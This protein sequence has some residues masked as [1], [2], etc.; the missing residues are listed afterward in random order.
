MNNFTYYIPTKV[1]FGKDEISKLSSLLK[2]NNVTKVMVAFGGGSIK[3]NGI[4]ESIQTELKKE[5]ISLVEF[6]GIEPNPR[7]KSVYDGIKTYKENGCDFILAVGGGSTI[8]AVKAMS[9]GITYDGDVLELLKD[10]SKIT[11]A[12]P[13]GVILTMAGTGSELDCLSVISVG[14]EHKKLVIVNQNVFPK[15]SILDPTYT[16]TVPKHHSTAGCCDIL[17][18][19]MEQ[20]FTPN[21]K[22][23]VQD[24]MNEG[25]MKSVIK[26]SIRILENPTDYDARANIMWASSQALAGYQFAL[27][28]SPFRFSMHAIGH[29]LS[30][31]YDITHGVTLALITP[32]YM[33][34]TLKDNSVATAI[35]AKFARHVFDVQ[36]PNDLEAAK[37]GI[38]KLEHFYALL[39]MPSSLKNVGVKSEDLEELAT[40]ATASG[41]FGALKTLDKDDVVEILKMSY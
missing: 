3:K 33:R 12:M 5:D 10:S 39:E 17:S 26:N 22:T 38:E 25:L 11:S 36:E 18:H 31:M 7:I 15:F 2:E 34:Y 20:Y 8:D 1:C 21:E 27:G 6:G 40:N 4:F 32:S 19:L 14:D 24:G 13:F 30:S 29:E 37:M 9:A 28:K 23:D 41:S 16:Y 35:F